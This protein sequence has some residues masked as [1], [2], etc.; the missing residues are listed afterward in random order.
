MTKAFFKHAEETAESGKGRFMLWQ[1][2]ITAVYN[3][4]DAKKLCNEL[5]NGENVLT[6]DYLLRINKLQKNAKRY[7]KG[8]SL[9]LEE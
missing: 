2:D 3:R 6:V 8:M 4:L 9:T 1:R 5:A 7:Y